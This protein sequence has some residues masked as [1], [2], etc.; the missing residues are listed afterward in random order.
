MKSPRQVSDSEI[1]AFW[2]WFQTISS[3]LGIRLDNQSLLAE[4]DE[5]VSRLGDVSWEV[6]PGRLEEN[7]LVITPDGSKEWLGL[8]QHFVALAPRIPGW[9][10]H[11]A[12]PP[13]EWDLRFSVERDT[14]G[15]LDID[16]REWKYVLFRFADHSFDIVVEQSNHRDVSASDR[17]TAAVVLLDGI[18]GEAKRLEL[19]GGIEPVV[20]LSKEH[21]AKASPVVVLA[22]HLDSLLAGTQ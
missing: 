13:R 2:R 8:T 14:G 16:A 7:A 17:Y 10:F 22:K 1:Q 5:R 12:R 3:E 21:A 9:E 18:L 19:I 20:T 4:L 6:G 15:I 11:W